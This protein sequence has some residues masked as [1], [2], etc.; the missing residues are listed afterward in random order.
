MS[1]IKLFSIEEIDKDIRKHN[2]KELHKV[3]LAMARVAAD[4]INEAKDNAD[5]TDRTSI[6]R[7]STGFR[8]YEDKK[9]IGQ[10]FEGKNS[11]GVEIG[12]SIVSKMNE[13]RDPSLIFTAGAEYA[14]SVRERGYTVLNAFIDKNEIFNEIKS[15]LE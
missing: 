9:I 4:V 2:N 6:L 10:L 12:K 3:A 13:A 7:S 14:T 5:Y 1:I 11:E 15:Y 8:V